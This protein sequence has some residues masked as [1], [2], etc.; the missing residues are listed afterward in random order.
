[1]AP[2]PSVWNHQSDK[3]LLLAIIE[4]KGQLKWPNISEQMQAKGYTFTK[5]ACR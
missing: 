3:D 1:M 4:E 5:E 2:V